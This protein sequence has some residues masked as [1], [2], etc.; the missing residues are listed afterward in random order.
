[1]EDFILSIV[2]K[3]FEEYNH[4][5]NRNDVEGAIKHA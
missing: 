4:Y 3:E 1:M 5:Y 2:D